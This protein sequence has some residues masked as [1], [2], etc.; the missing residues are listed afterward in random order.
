MK[1][2]YLLPLCLVFVFSSCSSE[3]EDTEC[4]DY[5]EANEEIITGVWDW[6]PYE[7][8]DH[9]VEYIGE[10]GTTG[11]ITISRSERVED[12]FIGP[13]IKCPEVSI[14]PKLEI[15]R[16]GKVIFNA[17]AEDVLFI[18]GKAEA[19][20]G[21]S[22]VFATTAN[23][24]LRDKVKID[25]MSDAGN[26]VNIRNENYNNVVVFL[27]LSPLELPAVIIYLQEGVGVLGFEE[28]GELYLV[29]K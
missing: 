25:D 7:R 17:W 28:K 21:A 15:S 18:D 10:A 20:F 24:S 3:P 11:I 23:S 27:L 9:E 12:N 19:I 1:I 6:F 2:Q 29:K 4:V 8:G 14:S 13:I 16:N 26:T 5:F 22:T